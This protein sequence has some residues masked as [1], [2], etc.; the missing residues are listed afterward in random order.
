MDNQKYIVENGRCNNPFG[1]GYKTKI[2]TAD[3][4]VCENK[5]GRIQ[6]FVERFGLNYRADTFK[7]DRLKVDLR[8]IPRHLDIDLYSVQPEESYWDGPDRTIDRYEEWWGSNADGKPAVRLEIDPEV[9]TGGPLTFTTKEGSP[10]IIGWWNY[11]FIIRVIF[12]HRM[13][14]DNNSFGHSVDIWRN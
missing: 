12:G 4:I 1:L 2:L 3:E 10:G 11:R 13:T 5:R 8:L 6:Q 14:E 7:D 9:V